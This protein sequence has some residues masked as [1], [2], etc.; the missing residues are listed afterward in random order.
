MDTKAKGS[1]TV[2]LKAEC[3]PYELRARIIGL[4][5]ENNML[6]KMAKTPREDKKVGHT[7]VTVADTLKIVTKKIQDMADQFIANPETIRKVQP[8]IMDFK[9]ILDE[10]QSELNESNFQL[11]QLEIIDRCGKEICVIIARHR[12][13]EKAERDKA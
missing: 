4:V 1:F 9:S 3:K 8:K 13:I 5:S 7:S 10:T 12:A 6:Q 11:Q 2:G